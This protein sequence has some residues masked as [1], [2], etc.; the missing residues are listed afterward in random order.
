MKRTA[1]KHKLCRRLGSCIWGNPKCPSIRRPYPPGQHG[2]TRRGKL[3]TYGELLLEKQKVRAHYAVS[4][5]QLQFLYKKA[6]EGG[7]ST[8]E[9]LLRS[10]ELRL[11]TV[12]WRSGLAPTIF[13]ARQAVS[14]RHVLVDGKIVDRSSYRVKPGQVVSINPQRSPALASVA[15]RSDVAPPEYLEVDRENVRVKVLREPSLEEIPANVE[16]MRVIEFYAR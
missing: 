5:R 11:A 4:E 8:A 6:R 10:L 13:A 15:Q 7:G 2:R 1:A 16:I 9:K 14:H 12:V 3:S